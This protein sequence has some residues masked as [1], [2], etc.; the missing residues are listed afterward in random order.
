MNRSKLQKPKIKDL[1]RVLSELDQEKYITIS[2]A[3]TGW[4]IDVINIDDREGRIELWGDY[5]EMNTYFKD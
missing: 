3:D 4:T 2:D 5:S 1:I